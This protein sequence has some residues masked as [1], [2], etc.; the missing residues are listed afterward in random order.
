ML[1]ELAK[2]AQLKLNGKHGRIRA[3][4]FR[5]FFDSVLTG[6]NVNAD[7][8]HWFMGH[9][10][11]GQQETYFQGQSKV[12]ELRQIYAGIEQYL[13]PVTTK[14]V[15]EKQIQIP[16]EVT[17]QMA[18]MYKDIKNEREMRLKLTQDFKELQKDLKHAMEMIMEGKED[19]VKLVKPKEN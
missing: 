7:I 19:K 12:E 10:L 17:E 9:K 11:Q 5:K 4:C 8:V 6:K 13:T 18:Q 1:R 2:K 15:I 16:T 14:V 3:H